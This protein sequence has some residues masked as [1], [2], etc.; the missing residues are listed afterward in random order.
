MEM[1]LVFP[2]CVPVAAGIVFVFMGKPKI[3]TIANHQLSE[4]TVPVTT[5][6]PCASRLC[7]IT[8]SEIIAPEGMIQRRGRRQYVPL[9]KGSVKKN[10]V[11]ISM[12][13]K[14]N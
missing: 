7:R 6:R 8:F 5:N 2:F 14:L 13:N 11:R 1:L 12:L 4:G 10:I 9:P 3:S